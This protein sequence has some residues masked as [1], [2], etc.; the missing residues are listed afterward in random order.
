M[1]AANAAT[2]GFVTHVSSIEHEMPD[3]HPER[4]DRIRAITHHLEA[5][6]LAQRMMMHE[7]SAA[8]RELLALVHGEHHL[9]FL[10]EL[11]A[12]G[13]GRIDLDT[14]M[15]PHSLD[16]AR[17]GTQGLVDATAKVLDGEWTSAF[18]CTR[19]PG[20]HA[21]PERPMGFCL[22]NHVAIA[23]RWAITSGRVSRVAILDWDAHHG[24]GTQDTFWTDP[25][26]LYISLHQYPWYPGTGDATERGEGEGAGTTVNVPLPSGGAEDAYVKAFDEVI[27]PAVSAFGPELVLISAGF[28]A[29]HLDPLCMMRLG[30]G[31]FHRLT[32]RAQGWGTGPVCVLEGGYDLD[33][34]AW[35]SGAMV[36][37]LLGEEPSGV[38]DEDLE[39]LPGHPEALVWVDRAAALQGAGPGSR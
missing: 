17:R 34:L 23:A 24:N 16:A 6:G 18:V 21:T 9:A 11:D 1:T 30:A 14:S 36:S 13:G 20:H 5:S 35:S 19:P 4:A 37:A 29:H 3:G 22:T 25:A 8:P 10:E 15:G 28:D 32:R 31:A 26:V 7:P 2:V 39:A 12:A 27:E 33:A 38:P